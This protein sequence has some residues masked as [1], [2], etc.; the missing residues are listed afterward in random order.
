MADDEESLLGLLQEAL[1]RRGFQVLTATDG[2][3]ALEI[4]HST[5]DLQ[6]VVL[7]VK[8]P[9]LSGLEACRAMHSLRPEVPIL[10]STGF[11]EVET[12]QEAQ[13]YGAFAVLRKP[14]RV[15][16]LTEKLSAALGR[17]V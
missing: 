1:G 10:L 3:R 17:R 4:F 7:D 8:M 12:D 2:R 9:G 15:G 6:A 5:P 13:D 14:F 16:A 11:S